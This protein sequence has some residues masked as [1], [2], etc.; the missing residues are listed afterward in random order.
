[1][2]P[3]PKKLYKYRPFHTNSVIEM[4]RNV[5]YYAN[6]KSFNDPADCSP[7]VDV[8]ITLKDLER[9]CKRMLIEE[10]GSKVDSA[11]AE[12]TAVKELERIRYYASEPNDDGS[13]LNMEQS[14]GWRLRRRIE[15]CL[16]SS[17]A[18]HGVLSLAKKWD[19]PLMWS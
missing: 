18:M 6:P 9:L 19:C 3:T 7:V 10:K 16:N 4:E 14:Y 13:P 2:Q 17:M 5:V 1:M 12:K 8:D 11:T 15:E